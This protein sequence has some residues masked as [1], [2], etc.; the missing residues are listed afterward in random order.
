MAICRWLV[1]N[2]IDCKRLIAVG[3]G[4]MKPIEDSRTPEGKA[5]NRRMVFELAALRGHLIGGADAD[6][7]GKVAGDLCKEE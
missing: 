5:K 1:S 4:S 7:G 3:F 2:G 6:G